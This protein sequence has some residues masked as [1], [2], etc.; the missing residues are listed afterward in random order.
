MIMDVAERE[1]PDII[2]MQEDLQGC[3]SFEVCRQLKN[4]YK[5]RD[6]PVIIVT[7]SAGEEAKKRFLFAGAVDYFALPFP[8]GQLAERVEK[9]LDS[10][11]Y[12]EPQNILIAEDSDTIR[13][14]IVK[15]LRQQGHH[16]TEARDGIEAWEI[17]QKDNN[18]DIILTDI[19]MPNLDG[20]QLCRFVR[21]RKE[22]E[23]VPIIVVSTIADK[24]D[25]AMLLNSGAD[26]YII[27]PFA[28][29]EFLARLRAHIRARQLYRELNSVNGRLQNF[30]ESLE[31][32]VESRTSDL[33][34]ANLESLMM[35]AVASEYRDADTGNHVRRI[36][37]F[38][39]HLALAMGY[40]ETK[41]IE[42]SN[43]SI[44]H[45]VGKIAIP[46]S[47][48]KKKGKLTV[49]EFET[50]KTHTVH[51]E[52]ILSETPF[53]SLSR[54]VARC[55]HE[56][57]DGSGY[58]DGLSGYHIPLAARVTAVADV[59]DALVSKRV[60][61]DAWSVERTYKLIIEEAGK[62]FDPMAVEAFEKIFNDGTITGIYKKYS[63]LTTVEK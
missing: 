38:S 3:S 62:H 60:Y 39:R 25:I 2:A 35:L 26:D 9:L 17:L 29:E 48:L 49:Q 30:T 10:K 42:I 21:G 46:D 32:M 40:S 41:S 57:F 55:H 43:A 5:T 45:D 6:I 51:G 16:V 31:K 50:M 56:K 12:V 22:L 18:I 4:N 14:I 24:E 36:S 52:K 7:H 1:R 33:Y 23:F 47:I 13:V 27:K 54:Q 63:S 34:E 53:F 61:K 19:N 37:Y 8:P 59:Y 15:I 11:A 44:V 28:T 58:P 20:H